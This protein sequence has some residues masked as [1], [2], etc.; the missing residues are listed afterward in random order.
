MDKRL[1]DDSIILIGP[2]GA[3]K[4]TVAKELKKKTGMPWRN[5]DSFANELR[6]TVFRNKNISADDFNYYMLSTFL[7]KAQ[8]NNLYGIVDFGAGHSVF[9][10]KATSEKVRIMLKPFKNVVLLLPCEDEERALNIMAMRHK[11]KKKTK[12]N[13]NFFESQCNKE[14]ATILIYEN[15]RNPSEIADEIILRINERKEQEME[16][17]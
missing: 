1:Y 4:T 10:D 7:K 9:D 11:S 13:K 16:R 12:D 17:E 8:Q 5:L 6:D 15:D 2:S 3:G 14:L